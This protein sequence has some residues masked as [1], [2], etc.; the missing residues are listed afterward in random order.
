[1]YLLYSKA[2][3]PKYFPLKSEHFKLAKTTSHQ[4]KMSCN[5]YTVFPMANFYPYP[6]SIVFVLK[7]VNFFTSAAYIHVHF[8]RDFIMKANIRL[9]PVEQ[10]DF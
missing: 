7:N 8:R 1:M 5:K 9:A 6:A 3:F 2:G 10:S 4:R